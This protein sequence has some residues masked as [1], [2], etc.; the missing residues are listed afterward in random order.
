[1]K[2][3]RG[4]AARAGIVAL[5]VVGLAVFVPLPGVQAAVEDITTTW[6]VPV[7]TA[8]SASFPFGNTNITFAPGS[9]TFSDE[10]AEDQV[11]AVGAYN[12]TNDGNVNIDVTA[13][14]ATDFPSG[15]TEFRTCDA[16]SGD[17]PSGSCW[18]WTDSNETSSTPEIISN[19]APAGIEELWA[20]STGTN[21]V[22]GYSERTY[23][24]TSSQS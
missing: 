24:L 17:A 16:S 20:W 23:R 2:N 6:N 12:I 15:V 5:L 8:L 22:G 19:L 18:W 7:S 4:K 14:F 9:A 1:M 21:V 10:P 13:T 11:D 3:K